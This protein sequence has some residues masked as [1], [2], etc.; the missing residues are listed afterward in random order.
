MQCV[1]LTCLQTDCQHSQ[2]SRYK[3]Q[4]S[5]HQCSWDSH[6]LEMLVTL[7]QMGRTEKQILW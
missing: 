6:Q 7:L 5:Q 4:I 2:Y 3:S 1:L